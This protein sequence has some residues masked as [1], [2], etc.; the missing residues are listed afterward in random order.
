M[1]ETKAGKPYIS[2]KTYDNQQFNCWNDDL[3][4]A[5]IGA[6]DQEIMLLVEHPPEGAPAA[7]RPKITELRL[8]EAQAEAAPEVPEDLPF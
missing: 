5:L 2:V 1:K 6:K 4:D 7:A 3:H 8:V